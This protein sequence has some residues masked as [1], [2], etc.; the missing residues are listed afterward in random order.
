MKN[1]VLV[2]ALAG[3]LVVS[4]LQGCGA[5]QQTQAQTQPS[6]AQLASEAEQKRRWQRQ[7]ADNIAALLNQAEQALAQDKLTTPVH[8]NALDR[9]QAVLLME[10]GNTAAKSGIDRVAQRYCRLAYGAIQSGRLQQA[11]AYLTKAQG[12][13]PKLVAIAP[14]RKQL[15]AARTK[16]RQPKQ[17][18]G[19]IELQ[20][21]S[22]KVSLPATPLGRRSEAL[23]D[24][25]KTLALQVKEQDAY[26]LIVARNDAE[27]RWV[28]QTMKSALPGYRLRGNIELGQVPQIELQAPL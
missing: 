1:S 3:T 6:E 8:D 22:N 16:A 14:L 10:P 18:V 26:V 5:G 4:L 20:A 15:A 7:R 9:Y 28:Y 11:Q 19:P 21:N 12:I 24:A 23:A 2:T 25:L 13:N 17:P 27:G